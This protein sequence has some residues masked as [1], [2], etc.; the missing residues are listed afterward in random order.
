M[1]AKRRV[2]NIVSPRPSDRNPAEALSPPNSSTREFFSAKIQSF[3]YISP[4]IVKSAFGG[5][6]NDSDPPIYL[7]LKSPVC[8]RGYLAKSSD[9][10]VTKIKYKIPFIKKKIYLV[11]SM[12]AVLPAY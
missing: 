10:R 7:L 4:S 3:F 9:L 6:K 5:F 12:L 1:P 2:R 11:F 8:I